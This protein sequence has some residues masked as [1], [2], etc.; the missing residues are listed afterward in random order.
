MRLRVLSDLHLELEPLQLERSIEDVVLL[1]GDI[2]HRTDGLNWA[3]RL[4][5]KIDRPVVMIAGN[6][7]FYSV[8]ESPAATVRSTL[9]AL[10]SAAA[11]T[12]G[13]V[14]FLES[15][16]VV[17]FIGT[18]LWTDFALLGEPALATLIAAQTMN[19]Y[20]RIYRNPES[21][22]TALEVVRTHFAY[23]KFIAEALASPFAG[24]TVVI[25]HHSPSGRSVAG[26]Y[27]DP[28]VAPSYASNLDELV[29]QSGAALWVHGHIHISQDYR[30][31]DTRV[32][33][34]P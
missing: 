11:R 2:G 13:R 21:N 5:Q 24:Q 23:R 19:D 14:T 30:I 34:N 6:H 16:V 32:V 31:G 1:P 3:D 12:A 9:D 28:R 25:T 4:S 8:R 33:C 17:R 26:R 22:I 15:E 18:T 20:R 10:H 7:E 29:A 27:A